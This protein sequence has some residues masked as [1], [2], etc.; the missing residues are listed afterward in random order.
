MS[1][2]RTG[3]LVESLTNIAIGYSL[4]F[5]GNLVILPRFGY[6]VTV[7]DTFWIGIWF[8]GISI[9]RS[10]ALRRWF[11]AKRWFPQKS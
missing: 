9:V 1:Q 11:N 5:I 8:T 3:S 4:N 7:H 6:H 2:S 10:Y